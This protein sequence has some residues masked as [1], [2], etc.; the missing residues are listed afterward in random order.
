MR[1]SPRPLRRAV[2]PVRNPHG[3]IGTA[4]VVAPGLALT[5]LHV[6]TPERPG[7]LSLGSNYPV[8]AVETLPVAE[9]HGVQE[10]AHRS[11]RRAQRLVG[12]DID[13]ALGTVDLVLLAVPGLHGPVLSPRA[14][15]VEVGEHLVVPG[16]PGGHWCVSQGPVTGADEADFAVQ[17]L[18][19][20]GASGAPALDRDHRLAG[21]VT[22]DHEAATVCIG[23]VLVSTFL[24]QLQAVVG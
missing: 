6:I 22:L 5:A 7:S 11:Q 8:V 19:G 2:L 12:G 15:P 24:Q 3:V 20:P 14:T 17:M 21:V 9:Y 13:V 4:T 16:Y 10:H 18:L 23:P 1:L